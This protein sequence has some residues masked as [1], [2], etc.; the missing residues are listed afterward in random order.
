MSVLS[1][2]I[3][4]IQLLSQHA[5][6]ERTLSFPLGELIDSSQI[7]CPITV[8]YATI[9]QN[10]CP[11]VATVV[12]IA[13][14]LSQGA[15][16]R[17]PSVVP[18]HTPCRSNILLWRFTR[19]GKNLGVLP[20]HPTKTTELA[21][22]LVVVTMVVPVGL[23]KGIIANEVP[24]PHPLHDLHWERQRC[25]PRLSCL[26]ILQIEMRRTLIANLRL[27]TEIVHYPVEQIRLLP[28]AAIVEPLP[29]LHPTLDKH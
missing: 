12:L 20:L 13:V 5:A 10:C 23:N 25:Q 29:G 18:S 1:N 22:H 17:R 8:I 11:S 4:A 24:H 28:L 27:R 2:L 3:Q 21:F 19:I 7:R 6:F 14:L 9:G 16:M 15:L 26:P